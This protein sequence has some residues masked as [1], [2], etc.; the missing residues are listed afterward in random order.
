MRNSTLYDQAKC[1]KNEHV[2]V[3]KMASKTHISWKEDEYELQLK[4][5]RLIR[6]FGRGRSGCHKQMVQ[7]VDEP[8]FPQTKYKI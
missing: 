4:E 6:H 3:P 8:V 1:D 5:Q 7:I 2:F